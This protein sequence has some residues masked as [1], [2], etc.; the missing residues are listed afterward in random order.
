M[1]DLQIANARHFECYVTIEADVTPCATH[2]KKKRKDII[3]QTQLPS[4]CVSD[5]DDSIPLPMTPERNT[6]S[7]EEHIKKEKKMQYVRLTAK[8]ADNKKE[9]T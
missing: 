5:K 2:I 9:H 3:M 4:T 7:N 6:N 1:A 8:L